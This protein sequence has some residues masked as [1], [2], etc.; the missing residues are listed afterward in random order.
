ML[1]EIKA[2]VPPTE[3]VDSFE[4]SITPFFQQIA[5]NRQEISE[6]SKLQDILLAE[7]SS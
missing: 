6:L 3:I 7:L 2:V 4:K 1:Y 5:S